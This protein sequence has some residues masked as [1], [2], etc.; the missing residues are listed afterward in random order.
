MPAGLDRSAISG[1]ISERYPNA[2]QRPFMPDWFQPGASPLPARPDDA[3]RPGERPGRGDLA[4]GDRPIPPDVRPPGPQPPVPPGPRPPVPPG[5]RPPA[6]HPPGWR[7]PVVHPPVW[8]P[9]YRPGHYYPPGFWWRPVTPVAVTG[10]FVGWWAQPVYYSYGSGGNVYYENN[11]VYVN[12]EQY[13]SPEQYYQDTSKLAASVPEVTDAQAEGME[14]MPLGVFAVTHGDVN[15]TNML[16]QLAVNKE[17][18][19]AGTFYNESTEAGHPVEGMVDRKTQRAA[20][21][22]ADGTNDNV[23]METGIYNLTQD[24]VS[25]LVHFGPD[26]TQTWTLVRVEQPEESKTE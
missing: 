2:A 10:W 6:P 12:G 26:T 5:P 8:H 22:T 9:W 13:G 25:V 15:D 17:G 1:A 14:W 21:K 11:V 20:W 19:I 23:V 18:V 4:D 16:L 3:A 7:P 24:E